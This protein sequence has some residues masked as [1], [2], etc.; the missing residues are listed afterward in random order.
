MCERSG[1]WRG[2]PAH[3][4]RYCYWLGFSYQSGFFSRPD[5]IRPGYEQTTTG[6]KQDTN[7]IQPTS[8]TLTRPIFAYGPVR[9]HLSALPPQFICQQQP[10]APSFL[11]ARELECPQANGFWHTD[12]STYALSAHQARPSQLRRRLLFLLAD[13]SRLGAR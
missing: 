7:R 6:Y 10:L 5:G 3:P 12:Q 2:L 13:L 8:R 4:G 1:G 11:Q 9:V